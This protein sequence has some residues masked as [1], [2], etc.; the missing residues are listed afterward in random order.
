MRRLLLCLALFLCLPAAALAAPSVGFAV[1]H[2]PD[3]A[4]G[5]AIEAG[6]W[7]PADAPEQ[8]VRL[9][10]GDQRVAPGAA[11]V[12]TGLPLVVMSHGNGG[13]FGSH[14][15]TAL[16]LARQ[17]F[18]VAALTHTGD[19]YADQSLAADMAN[20][21]RQLHVLIGW[22]LAEWNFHGRLDPERVGAFGFSSGG[23]TVLAAAGGEPD[24]TTV[25]RHCADHPA[26]YA[27]V[28]TRSHPIP[29]LRPVWVHDR[30]IKAVV[31]AAPA[32][33]FAFG[34]DGLKGVRVPVQLWRADEDEIL[35]APWYA[36]AVRADLP[37]PPDFRTAP[38]A[39]HFDFLSPC[40]PAL[41]AQVPAICASRPGFDRAAFHGRFNAETV[42]FFKARL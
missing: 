24:L 17:G 4:G 6:V 8:T 27:C 7:Y 31:S 33:G 20:R 41:A 18:V 38:N 40:T 15:D 26:F 28:L 2:I 12:G 30:R 29:P 37:T 42:A 9:G 21:P 3:P 39:G 32:L 1:V 19:N 35:P 14:Y 10:L 25:A 34:R 16:A 5:P 13:W 36:D 23:F 11:P 22:M